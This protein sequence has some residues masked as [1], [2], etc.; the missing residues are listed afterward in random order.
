MTNYRALAHEMRDDP[1]RIE[2]VLRELHEAKRTLAEVEANARVAG[3]R[4][5]LLEMQ[6]Q[7]AGIGKVPIWWIDW[8]PRDTVYQ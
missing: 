2:E 1:K 6:R 7:I 8:K 4:M 5:G 3:Y